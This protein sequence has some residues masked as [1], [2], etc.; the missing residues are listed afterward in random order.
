[1]M[2]RPKLD[3]RTSSSAAA[4]ILL[5]FVLASLHGCA[6]A[7]AGAAATSA[8]PLAMT[9]TEMAAV[10]HAQNT[11]SAGEKEEDALKCNQLVN[12]P[13]GVEEVR[14]TPDL[15]LES[16]EIRIEPT[17]GVGGMWVVYRSR[18]SSP[19]GW[20]RQ[21]A[22]DKLHFNPPL[23]YLLTDKKP[24]YLIYAPAVADSIHDSEIMMSLADNFPDRVGSFEWNGKRYDYT[25][26]KKLPC[27]ANPQ[28]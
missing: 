8:I 11:E 9:S 2:I 4:A 18:G 1:M 10:T 24:Q 15:S 25:L 27:F 6:G 19:Q 3:F 28:D 7:A 14:R 26:S 12:H 13:P 23:E 5:S 22:L 21:K 17:G 20:H 16:R